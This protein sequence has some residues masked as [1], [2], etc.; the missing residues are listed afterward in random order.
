MA[1][2][3]PITLPSAPKPRSF[4]LSTNSATALTLSP[5]TGSS[6]VYKHP[7]E[8]W[9]AEIELPPMKRTDAADWIAALTSLRGI[10]GTMYLPA[11]GHESPQ[12]SAGGS[13]VAYGTSSNNEILNTQGWPASQTVL[14]AGDFITVNNQLLQILN[15][16]DSDGSGIVALDI[17]PRY[18]GS[19]SGTPAVTTSNP[20]GVF[21]LDAN[22]SRFDLN[23]A[24]VYGLGFSAMEAL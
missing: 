14:K 10:Y 20:F 21:R 16:A 12:G 4:A 6:Q 15:D 8:F 23:A 17:W 3:F 24:L 5:F 2:T 22:S 11:Y 7:G 13:P 18:R 1:V 9:T 19:V